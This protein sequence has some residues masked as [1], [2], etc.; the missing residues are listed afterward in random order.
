[1]IG[2]GGAVAVDM[3]GGGHNKAGSAGDLSTVDM[4]P[5]DID[6][7]KKAFGENVI[8][9]PPSP[10]LFHLI[11]ENIKGDT[12]IQVL[13]V[14]A[15]LVLILG[16]LKCPSEGWV[17]GVAIFIAV[18]I[19]LGVT[20]GNDWSK[21]RK[22]RRLLLMQTDKRVRVIR[23]GIKD[24]ISSWD[25]VAG[26]LVEV[27]VGD[28]VPADGILVVGNR[29]VVD[30]SPLT[31]ESDPVKKSPQ[32][33]PF[34]FSGCQVNEGSGIMLVTAVGYNSS[35]GKIQQ[36]LSSSETEQTP[37][38]KKLRRLA[39]FI[40]KVGVAAAVITFLGLTIV[41]AVD[42]ANGKDP[43]A[44]KACSSK[45][46]LGDGNN[47]VLDR[48]LLLAEI[49]VIGV[50]VVVVAVPEG[51]PLAV[52]ISLAFSMFKM[53]QDNCFVRHLDA[54][55]TMGEATCIC[56]DKTGTLTENRMTVVKALVGVSPSASSGD[57]GE[58]KILHG[59]GSGE[60]DA[61]PFD[62]NAVPQA[63]RDL[64]VEAVSVNST[65][66]VKY[67]NSE[68]AEATTKGASQPTSKQPTFIGSATEGALLV[69]ADKI[70]GSHA[71]VRSA[72][73]K[74]ENGVWSFSSARKRMSTFVQ[75]TAVAPSSV[76]GLEPTAHSKHTYRLYT[77]GASEIITD[78]CTRVI[79][80]D[81]K[82]TVPM[83]SSLK[84]MINQKIVGWASDGLRTLVVAYRDTDIDLTTSEKSNDDPEID[85]VF[86]CLV[87]IRDPLRK[88]VPEAVAACQRAGLTVRM[89]T[90]D[91]LLTARKI[92][93][94]CHIL[95][96]LGPESGQICM[97]GPEFRAL[98]DEERRKVV[99]KLAVLARSSPQDKFILVSLLKAM[100]EVVAV[101]GD[102][103]NDAPALKEGDIGFS[104]GIAGTQIAMN[105]SDIVLLDDNF[106]TLVQ[107]IRWG[108]NVLNSVRKFLQFQLA[109]NAIAILVTF[110]GS[111]TIG[112]SPLSTVQLLW[113]N[114]IMDSIGAL[115]LATDEPDA[116]I[117]DRPPHARN[118][119]LLSRA[120][121]EHMFI[122]IIYQTS[123][124]LALLYTT[125][126]LVPPLSHIPSD[127]SGGDSSLRTK[128]LVFSTF[129]L[130]QI[131]NMTMSRQLYG[132]VNVFKGVLKNRYFL[133]LMAL[134]V[135]IQVIV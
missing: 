102:G 126:T 1:M 114:L 64:I 123:V 60:S 48:M 54:S 80:P 72:I 108:R 11:W 81:G 19:V 91:N 25:I 128:T 16:T 93:S 21:D 62:A 22:F 59:E 124:L 95:K 18:T 6:L 116:D 2:G 111:V 42:W 94:E 98:S 100:G 43:I 29:L 133:V 115:A 36:L 55:E 56:T 99:P 135:V 83:T 121:R 35:G 45:G 103:T 68:E 105:A 10:S 84:A 130:L 34:M 4:T 33:A 76:T 27:L 96:S 46:L 28:E 14:G 106:V 20:A 101:T 113:V 87:G 63:V 110:V 12:I 125:D 97:E 119:N 85:L 13:L 82:S 53:I 120:M 70:G 40:G 52:T 117:L 58:P 129:V 109:V 61:K 78:L 88:D 65:C 69:W 89:V 92:A 74:V 122:Q 37:L 8:P 47:A 79:T 5:T 49:A 41:W 7:R 51:L 107:A 30:E 127:L 77:K 131:S 23:G 66:I 118:A 15:T 3:N 32:K 50:T 67:P 75:P 134:I 104:M 44:G 17:E 86:I 24:Q 57:A 26:D 112:T 9:P 71:D 31:G 132:E 73:P 90:G 38:Q 39:V